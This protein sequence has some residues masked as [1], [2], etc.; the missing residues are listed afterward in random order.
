MQKRSKNAFMQALEELEDIGLSRSELVA[1][2]VGGCLLGALG[3]AYA[4]LLS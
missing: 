4:R 2:L 1:L 3:V